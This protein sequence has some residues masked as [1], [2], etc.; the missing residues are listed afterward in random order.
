MVLVWKFS[1]TF[2]PSFYHLSY[3][4]K[5]L[6]LLLLVLIGTL[7]AQ[8]ASLTAGSEYYIWLNIYEKLLGSNADG[9][10]PALSAF[11]TNSNA[12]SYVFVAEAS[13]ESGY[14]LLR[15]KSSGK[16]LA[17][18]SSNSY[19]V[20]FQSSKATSD[21][22]KWKTEVGTNVALVN[23]KNTGARLGIDGGAKGSEYVSVYYDKRKGSH[24]D[25]TVIPTAG[26]SYEQARQAYVSSIY[27]N[28]Q[29]IREID[30]IQLCQEDISRSDAID[31][32][33]TANSEPI[34]GN[35][36]VN[37][38]S[39]RTWLIFDNIQPSNVISNYLRYVHI[40]GATATNGG[41]CRVAIYLNGAAVI[42]TPEAPLT[43][44]DQKGRRGDSFT[45]TV[46]KHTDLGT[47]NNRMRSF[48][49]R[50]GYMATLASGKNGSGYSRVYVAD[51][52]DLNIDL[53]D[54]LNGRVSSIYLKPWQYVSKK[55]WGNTSGNSGANELRATWY[56][57]WSASYWSNNNQEYVPCRQHRYWPSVSE[58]NEHAASATLSINE[59]EHEDDQHNKS[60]C[61]CSDKWKNCTFMPDYQA[62]GARIGSPQPTDFSWLYGSGSFFENVDNMAYRC[63][64]AVTH[65]YWDLGGR[66][67]NSYASYVASHS[68][69]IWNNTGRPVWLTE[70]E[71]SAQ[72]NTNKISSYEQNRQYVQ[73][74]LEALD[75]APWVER[76][77]IYGVDMWQTYMFYEAN[78]SKGLTPAGQVYRDHRA[79]FAYNSA[80]TKEPIWWR[81]SAKTPSI[82]GSY[83]S[84][85]GMASFSIVNENT[86]MTTQLT[87]QHSTSNGVWRTL[88]TITD[89]ALFDDN[90]VTATGVDVSE[91]NMA[92]ERFRVRA[93]LQDGTN[94]TSEA[95]DKLS[96]LM[97]PGIEAISKTTIPGWTC[98]KTAQNGYTKGDSG[99]TYFEVWNPTAA[100]IRFNYYQDLALADGVYRLSARVFNSSNSVSGATVNQAVGLYAQTSR[101]RWFTPVTKDSEMDDA[102][103]LAIEHVVVTDGALRIGVTNQGMMTARWA[104]ADDFELTYL[105]TTREV[106]GYTPDEALLMAEAEQI[107]GWP[108]AEGDS[109][110]VTALIFNPSANSSLATGWTT[111]N[112]GFNT[113]EAWD[114]NNNNPYFDKWDSKAYKSS[115]EQQIDL[116]P[117]GDYVVSAML[118]C[119]EG[120]K[121]TFSATSGLGTRS[122]TFTGTG[123]TPAA[124]SSFPL[125]WQRVALPKLPVASGGSIDIKLSADMAAG[126]WWSADDFQL[127]WSGTI[128]VGVR[129]VST[130]ATEAAPTV[131]TLT[132]I[133]LSEPPSRPGLYIV[134]GRKVLIR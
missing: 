32:H 130:P 125:G 46:G 89:R 62:S 122:Q 10:S 65:A 42:P 115:L 2:A 14:V 21:V 7:S 93:T 50:R 80:Y 9:T 6:N 99:D 75:E 96:L 60:D 66:D 83:S 105:G 55:G 97:N 48:T 78:P 104:G 57:S 51:H 30:Y 37:L 8:A 116:L 33:L 26:V 45:P 132:G 54:A 128:P 112:V 5:R 67:A 20:V 76:Y 103:R 100:S 63:D 25:F 3:D 17:A 82:T 73:A 92:N 71:V 127:T 69:E 126:K 59:P 101:H 77:A 38:G 119:S 56:W 43:C 102:D 84:G 72:W 24:A 124:G 91:L 108:L 47:D 52:A 113:G 114:G 118:R 134:G 29:G 34:I 39:D 88:H 27:T 87:I 107:Q 79:T 23:K 109:R 1:V 40:N 13:G 95:I 64:F 85:S 18:S 28:A 15:Q 31:I 133:R 16:Y 12:D 74:L 121:L 120:A 35:S 44:Y 110:D 61:D 70:M 86:D 94:V 19:S 129:E 117:A 68:K 106:L 111:S 22:Y 98:T 90:V 36:T 4:M 81:P 123:A 53:P 41:N 49:L 131:T 11:G 58:V